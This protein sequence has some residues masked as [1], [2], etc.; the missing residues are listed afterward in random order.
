MTST[1][2]DGGVTVSATATVRKTVWDMGDG[3]IV[4]CEGANAAGMP[5]DGAYDAQPSPKCGHRYQRTSAYE[6]DKA[7]TVSVTVYWD[8]EWS[9]GGQ[10]GVLTTTVTAQTQLRVGEVQVIITDRGPGKG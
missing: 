10:S 3:T 4:S 1:A 2:T 8:V 9:G 7:F 6:P 5:Y